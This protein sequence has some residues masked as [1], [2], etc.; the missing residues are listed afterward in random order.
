MAVGAVD[1]L[2][3]ALPCVCLAVAVPVCAAAQRAAPGRR[4]TRAVIATH[5]TACATAALGA[6]QLLVSPSGRWGGARVS[7]VFGTAAS[8]GLLVSA[9]CAMLLAACVARATPWSTVSSTGRV[10]QRLSLGTPLALACGAVAVALLG[11]LAAVLAPVVMGQAPAPAFKLCIYLSLPGVALLLLALLLAAQG[12]LDPLGPTL[13]FALAPAMTIAAAIIEITEPPLPDKFNADALAVA[14]LCVGLLG[15]AFGI[16]RFTVKK[17]SRRGSLQDGLLSDGRVTGNAS[18]GGASAGAPGLAAR[19]ELSAA[20]G[21]IRRGSLA[22]LLW[23]DDDPKPT[24]ARDPKAEWEAAAARQKFAATLLWFVVCFGSGLPGVALGRFVQFDLR[25]DPSIQAIFGVIGAVPWNFK[26][27]AAFLSDTL[28]ICGRRRI[29]YLAMGVI[30]QCSAYWLIGVSAPDAETGIWAWLPQTNI[31]YALLTFM[32]AVGAM[33]TGVMCDTVV[34]ETSMRYERKADKGH[35][36]TAT[37]MWGG[38]AGLI[39]GLFAGWMIDPALWPRFTNRQMLRFVAVARLS[40]LLICFIL[41]DP[42]VHRKPGGYDEA[43]VAVGT[44]DDTGDDK[45]SPGEGDVHSGSGVAAAAVSSS[46]R[47]GGNC[48][49]KAATGGSIAADG[50]IAGD[51]SV[52]VPS[53]LAADDGWVPPPPPPDLD[54]DRDAVGFTVGED[55]GADGSESAGAN[56][57]TPGAAAN[58]DPEQSNGEGAGAVDDDDGLSEPKAEVVGFMEQCGQIW[59]AMHQDRIWRPMIFICI[60]A[61]VPGNGDAFNSFTQG[62]ARACTDPD[63]GELFPE[64]GFC[65]RDPPG[66]PTGELVDPDCREQPNPDWPGEGQYAGSDAGGT[67]GIEPMGFTSS[68]MAYVGTI[69]SVA[70]TIGIWIFKRYLMKA[71]WRPLFV[72]VILIS[73]AMSLSQLILIYQINQR[74]G[75]PNLVFA[76]GDDLISIICG[77]FIGMPIWVMMGQIVP[78]GTEASVFALVTSLQ[79]VGGTAGGAISAV[80]TEALGVTLRDYSRLADLVIITSLWKLIALP[81]V[82]LV[83]AHISVAREGASRSKFGAYLLGSTMVVGTAF[84]AG[85]AIIKLAGFSIG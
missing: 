56:S 27:A 57:T 58:P 80:L 1:V 5:F 63:T 33:F 30:A 29:P 65:E 19:A 3:V 66:D 28:P 36:Q 43:V 11:S 14:L 84:A 2:R 45:P 7:D 4:L 10:W 25:A 49:A 42:K 9:H 67:R 34:V 62:C 13:S 71:P 39:A 51:D 64:F 53:P 60:Y 61:L 46:A 37:W 68:M 21:R 77:Q 18:A 47:A 24:V 22:E 73:T 81:F 70:S 15:S 38:I 76:L 31:A 44:D 52:E 54:T 48:L 23:T 59:D 35:I 40:T 17:R 6:V 85:T 75:I 20:L 8:V 32:M 72:G 26:F 79:M 50:A 16:Y 55:Q 78:K 82:A 74:W 12:G 69:G 41:T 83:P